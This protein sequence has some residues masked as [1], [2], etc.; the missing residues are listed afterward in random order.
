MGEGHECEHANE[1]TS[2]CF[3]KAS[4]L[5][6]QAFPEVDLIRRHAWKGE[7]QGTWLGWERLESKAE[8]VRNTKSIFGVY[9]SL[10]WG[11]HCQTFSVPFCPVWWGKNA[12]CRPAS[13]YDLPMAAQLTAGCFSLEHPLQVWGP[14]AVSLLL[15]PFPEYFPNSL[16]GC[17]KKAKT[18]QPT[19]QHPHLPKKTNLNCFMVANFKQ[20]LSIV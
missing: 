5:W 2:S 20:V 10:I 8:H 16:L 11:R 7:W 1:E 15:F 12:N 19:N 17:F 4:L 13:P 9:P 6:S 18:N 3:L 14:S